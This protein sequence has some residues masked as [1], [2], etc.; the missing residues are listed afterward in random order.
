[1]TDLKVESDHTGALTTRSARS[2]RSY[3]EGLA[4]PQIAAVVVLFAIGAML[5]DGYATTASVLSMLIIASFLG[6]AAGGQTLVVL[7][8]GI[9]LSIPFVIGAANVM[10]ARLNGEGWPLWATLGA[11]LAMAV[12]VGVLNGLATKLLRIH[13]L[14]VT[15]ATGAI[16]QGALLVWTEG[17]V[18]GAAPEWL[19]GF[20]SLLSTTGP[21]PLPP[22]VVFW[23][24]V[25]IVL[26]VVLRKLSVARSVYAVGA[27]GRAADLTLVRSTGVWV[28]V[29]VASAI[30]AS[31]TGIALTGFSTTGYLNIGAQYLFTS[32][33][34]VVIG[35]TSLLG[36][37]GNYW[38]TALGALILTQIQT[39]MIGFGLSQEAQQIVLGALIITIMVLVGRGESVGRRI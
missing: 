38:R 32:I 4:L 37:R 9:D 34:A 35:G 3:T 13:S 10:M 33:A 20:V 19:T 23:I 36:A 7:V 5:L 11:I 15:L 31:L 14:I 18:T 12:S 16:V 24:A 28:L 22:I 30:M 25:T 21:I 2:I 29:F 6:L 26:S 27:N 8:G 39:I 1:M 17:N